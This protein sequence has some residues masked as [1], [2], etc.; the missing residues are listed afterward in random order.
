V[1][2]GIAA[3]SA[4]VL[5]AALAAGA[6]VWHRKR[7]AQWMMSPSERKTEPSFFVNQRSTRMN[8]LPLIAGLM[9]GVR[10]PDDVVAGLCFGTSA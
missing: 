4:A 9:P 6:W 2:A 10:A 7:N 1:I 8:A 3:A 5:L